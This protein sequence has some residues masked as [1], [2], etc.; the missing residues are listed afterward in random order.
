[1][2]SEDE[3][4]L[5]KQTFGKIES[6]EYQDALSLIVRDI[7]KKKQILRNLNMRKIR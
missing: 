3:E 6:G 4:L 5:F 2:A 1:M 7:N